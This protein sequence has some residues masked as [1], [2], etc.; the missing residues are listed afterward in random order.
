LS[1]SLTGAARPGGRAGPAPVETEGG[2]RALLTPLSALGLRYRP[3]KT[4]PTK[5]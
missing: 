5:N 4:S 2:R 3:I 1:I